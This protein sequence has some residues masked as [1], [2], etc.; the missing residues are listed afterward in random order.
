M[1][2]GALRLGLLGCGRI[3]RIFHLP[4]LA[5]M[6]GVELAAVAEPDADARSVA[7]TR[8]PGAVAVADW[9][10]VVADPGIDAVVVCLPSGMHAD[11]AC[12]AFAAGLHVYLEKPIATSLEDGCRVLDAW[13]AG[14]SVGM[15]GFDQRFSPAIAAL[16]REVRAGRVGAATGVRLAMGSGRRDSPDWKRSRATGGGV[17]LDLGSHMADLARFVLDEE[18][19]E[20]SAAAASVL[21]E[22]DTASFAMTLAG[23]RLAQAWVTL[24]GITESRLEVVGERGMLV[25]DRYA[26]T[27]RL[28]ALEPAWG[29]VARAREGLAQVARG[30]RELLGVARPLAIGGTYRAALEA[31]AAAAAAGRS[32][33][34][35][36]EDGFRSLAVVLAAEESA[37]TGRAV[38]PA[39]P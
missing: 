23:G 39:A 29:R 17:L 11:A 28:H 10:D 8:A 1:K 32:A 12:A 33:A 22:S 13:R 30:S 36:I 34:P 4:I 31:F 2:R 19:R 9:Q 7:G 6:R 26:G 25:A 3:A 35:D 14:R 37:R 24:A 16:R 38:A 5:A 15:A 18:V 27:L 20:V 21:S